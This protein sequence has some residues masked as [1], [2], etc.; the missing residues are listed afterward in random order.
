[1]ELKN[2]DKHIRAAYEQNFSDYKVKIPHL[3]HHNAFIVLANGIDARIGS[4]SSRFEHFHE[5]KRLE[6]ED[7]G[8]VDMETL[9][10]GI[11]NKENFLDLF[12]N[13]ILFDDS[14]G[15]TIKIVAQNHQYLGVNKAF[16]SVRD[17][18]TRQGK[19]GVFWHTQGSGKSYSMVFFTRK[20][21]RKLGAN[22]TFVICS[23]R[24]DLDSQIYK[25]FAGCGVVNN[26]KDPCRAISGDHLQQLL[27]LQKSHIF[28]LIQKFNQQIAQPYSLR[29]DIIVISD[30]AHRTQYGLL[31]RNMRDALSNASY[32][33][34]TGTPL[35]SDDQITRRV[36]GEYI[37]TYDFQRA[38]DDRSTVPLYYDSR[39][40]KLGIETTELNER[41]AKEIEELE[42]DNVDIEQRL[43]KAL[44]RDYHIITAEKRLDQIARDFVQH[45]ATAWESGKAMLICIDKITC[46][47]M[48][49]LIDKYWHK[50][51]RQLEKN[52][53][54]A[55]SDQDENYQR[56][57]I[58]WMKETQSAVIISEEQ[59]EIEKFR[60]W[61]LDILPYRKLIKD[62]FELAD[63][64]S[65]D[66]ESAF[67]KPDHPFRITIV[68]AMWLTGFDVPSLSILYL[69]KPLKAHT[70]MQAIARANRVYEGKTN[71]LIVDYCG[72]LKNLRAALKVYVKGQEGQ[73]NNENLD[74]TKPESELLENLVAAIDAVRIF[75]GDRQASLSD[76]V[77]NTGLA[78][79]AAIAAAKEAANQSDRTRKQLEILCRD[80]FNKFQAC[81][82]NPEVSQYRNSYNAIK[83][84][85]KLLQQDREQADISDILRQL[86]EIVNESIT[87]Q[88]N[89][90][91]ELTPI[92]DISQIDFDRLR[93]EFKRSPT[94][95]TTVQNLKQ[96]IENRLN[97]LLTQ[98]PQRTNLQKHYEE[99]V[100]EYNSEKDRVEIEVTFTALLDFTQ[101]LNAEQTR[102]MREGLD[103][104][105]LAIYDLLLKP[106][107]S[108]REIKRIKQISVELLATLKAQD[109]QV[110]RWCDKESTRDRVNTTI[111]NFHSSDN[112]GLPVETYTDADV[113][114]KAIALPSRT[115]SLSQATIANICVCSLAQETK[116][117]NGGN[118]TRNICLEGRSF[119]TKLHSHTFNCQF[120]VCSY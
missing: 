20:I 86:Q 46:I 67:K 105:S 68:C 93:A 14:S 21:H 77:E 65:L 104:E 63:G 16:Q 10:K 112:S 58:A 90:A 57:Q 35:L 52:L 80:V 4:L 118:R 119:T 6:E 7:K 2:V 3:F 73:D 30:E 9:L 48:H 29:D 79:N 62:G 34:F 108:P 96:S 95:N 41:I 44:K 53:R 49:Q 54:T 37:S 15:K 51:I 72:I 17:R 28:T 70:L 85:Y 1:M 81:I 13:F 60:K 76:I 8:I 27:G 32:I 47:R 110:D 116:K 18:Q 69:D 82:N 114:D 99:I 22:F 36:F 40:E 61:D 102:A 33:G 120:V 113:E 92:Y 117:A 12:E 56:R 64:Q 94:K 42:I 24:D 109:L 23:D 91:S 43:Q 75:L 115:Q 84:L 78:R 87:V 88:T 74:P 31:S 97:R 5:W 11:C 107:L 38:V 55:P 25:T 45:Y 89:R 111:H 19:L 103:E 83:L 100:A 106:D 101:T 26:D 50:H 71:G 66:V 39:G 98:N 59:G